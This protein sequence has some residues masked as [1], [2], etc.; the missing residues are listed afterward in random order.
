MLSGIIGVLTVYS[1]RI[2]ISATATLEQVGVLGVYMGFSSPIIAIIA[3]INKY[4]YPLAIRE[5]SDSNGKNKLHTYFLYIVVGYILLFY[6]GVWVYYVFFRYI[7]FTDKL[8]EY[9]FVFL[10]IASSSLVIVLYTLYSPMFIFKNSKKILIVNIISLVI[11][12]VLQ[13]FLLM[14]YG[15][16]VVGIGIV[17][18]QVLILVFSI[19]L[20]KNECNFG[21]LDFV[22]FL[23]VLAALVPILFLN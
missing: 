8:I 20:F 17:I 3:V 13:Y 16:K 11:G 23:I 7:I 9:N 2:V 15:F 10:H 14:F 18:T 5:L 21:K 22:L 1:S 4:Y 6:L 12:S 19:L